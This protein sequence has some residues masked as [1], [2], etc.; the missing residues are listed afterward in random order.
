[1]LMG[2]LKALTLSKPEYY[3][4]R[5][6]GWEAHYAVNCVLLLTEQIHLTELLWLS[7]GVLIVSILKPEDEWSALGFSVQKCCHLTLRFNTWKR[8]V[9]E[10]ACDFQRSLVII[11]TVSLQDI[12]WQQL[13]VTERSIGQSCVLVMWVS[14]LCLSGACGLCSAS[15]CLVMCPLCHMVELP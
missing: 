7:Y 5:N 9:F 2:Y 4:I 6:T 14:P 12:L 10:T 1:M 3:T 13:H 11:S 15:S 8:S